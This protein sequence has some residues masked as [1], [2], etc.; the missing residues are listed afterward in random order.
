MDYRELGEC[1]KQFLLIL[2]HDGAPPF[3]CPHTCDPSRS[4]FHQP[5][6]KF[7]VPVMPPRGIF[8]QVPIQENKAVNKKCTFL[9][10][11]NFTAQIV[12]NL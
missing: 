10:F 12:S 5:E 8:P 3:I 7:P 2:M 9:I 6:L 4:P 1:L 11:C